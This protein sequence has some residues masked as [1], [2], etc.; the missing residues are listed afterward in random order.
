MAFDYTDTERCERL[1]RRFERTVLALDF[2]GVLAIPYSA[3][4]VLFPGTVPLLRHLAG[5]GCTIIVTSK[6]PR[7]Y[8]VLKDLVEEGTIAA[9]RAG[10]RIKW[11]ETHPEGRY[12]DWLHHHDLT[13]D[14]AP[15]Y[16]PTLNKALHLRDMLADELA[17][18]RPGR[19]LFVDDDQANI[20][21][22]EEGNYGLWFS[23]ATELVP[24]YV[25]FGTVT[26][27]KL[28]G[29]DIPQF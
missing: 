12:E 3:P 17:G 10:S 16:S 26:A 13:A 29:L 14:E 20:D 9:I 11:W 28:L 19:L 21:D 2:D 8:P 25:G 18:L 23:P 1:F 27:R 7:A 5:R 15:A 6:N 24:S 22:V 4:E